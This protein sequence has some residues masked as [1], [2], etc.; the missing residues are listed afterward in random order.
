M[1]AYALSHLTKLNTHCTPRDNGSNVPPP[2]ELCA[3]FH[4]G[5]A[6]YFGLPSQSFRLQL[7]KFVNQ[8]LLQ[9]MRD[10]D[11]RNRW[12]EDGNSQFLH[13]TVTGFQVW[14]KSQKSLERIT[15]KLNGLESNEFSLVGHTDNTL[16]QGP[17]LQAQSPHYW[18]SNFG[19]IM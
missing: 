13:G 5:L 4:N 8:D 3:D 18:A 15:N 14:A 7:K 9:N 1:N 12:L 16:L 6:K 17:M 11:A 19:K 2:P 10:V